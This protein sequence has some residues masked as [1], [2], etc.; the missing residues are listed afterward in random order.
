MDRSDTI[1]VH[2]FY[3][4]VRDGDQWVVYDNTR[5]EDI[6]FMVEHWVIKDG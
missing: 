5:D 4:D 3:E 2:R 6:I 1:P